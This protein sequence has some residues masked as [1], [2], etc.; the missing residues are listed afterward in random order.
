MAELQAV[1]SVPDQATAELLK[2][3]LTDGGLEQVEIR[4]VPGNAYLGHSAPMDF[5]V[6]VPHADVERARLVLGDFESTSGQAATSQSA[7]G[8]ADA[9]STTADDGPS[10]AQR[11]PFV[12]WG[13]Y[14]LVLCTL[15]P[16]IFM[17]LDRAIET[18]R[19]LLR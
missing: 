9:P 3:V 15:G 7:T 18:V 14:A 17:M 4:P 2:E 16:M 12:R 5:E 13:F 10:L 11:K 19:N 1:T 6:R 8:Q